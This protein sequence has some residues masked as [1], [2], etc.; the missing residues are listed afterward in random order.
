MSDAL[1]KGVR[2]GGQL[3]A[4]SRR[5]VLDLVVGEAKRS[6]PGDCVG[7]VAFRVS[8]L[9]C[10]RAVVP[11]AVG[12]NDQAELGPVEVDL[13]PVDELFAER[14]RQPRSGGDRPEEDLEIRVGEP[15]R[16]S[17]ED[18]SEQAHAWLTRILYEKR[19][20]GFRVNQVALVGFVDRPLDPD[21]TEFAGEVDQVRTGVVTGTP[22]W[23]TT[24]SR[25]SVGRP[26]T[27]SP[28]LR[29]SQRRLTLMST[30]FGRSIPIP[31]IAAAL[32]WLSI[33][34]SPHA[35]TAAIHR[36]FLVSC[37]QPTA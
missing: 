36:R 29:S 31:H 17:V 1:A 5:F 15:E 18:V 3:I 37:G 30:T 23:I 25:A 10:G 14:G 20:Q 12:L 16:P 22:S 19:P 26:R 4:H 9:G 8:R 7:A 6:H 13:P 2:D 21:G 11:E 33:A 28:G 35:R 27:R 34:P 24:S 32:R